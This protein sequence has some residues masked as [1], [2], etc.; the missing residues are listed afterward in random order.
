MAKFTAAFC[1]TPLPLLEKYPRFDKDDCYKHIKSIQLDAKNETYCNC[2]VYTSETNCYLW[3]HLGDSYNKFER[4]DDREAEAVTSLLRDAAKEY[5]NYTE[6][7]T[8]IFSVNSFVDGWGDPLVRCYELYEPLN[9]DGPKQIGKME[10]VFDNILK[11]NIEPYDI[12]NESLENKLSK[13]PPEDLDNKLRSWDELLDEVKNP[14]IKDDSLNSKSTIINFL[15][16][17][18]AKQ[19]LKD[20]YTVHGWDN[21][22][23]LK[24]TRE[25]VID[26]IKGCYDFLCEIED[27]YMID[28]P[29]AMIQLKTLCWMLKDEVPDHNNPIKLANHIRKTYI[30]C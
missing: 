10:V 28:I 8:T 4:F 9:P 20:I 12:W 15:Y 24:Y 6:P 23:R 26:E 17:Y 11:G 29:K 14:H 21:R 27:D 5:F 16:Y 18:H 2:R 13:I 22:E 30:D 19:F 7:L 25:S 3:Y 1:T